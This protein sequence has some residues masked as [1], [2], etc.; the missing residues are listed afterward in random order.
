MRSATEAAEGVVA[1]SR[2]PSAR[3]RPL[4]ECGTS[5]AGTEPST[6]SATIALCRALAADA[7]RAVEAASEKVP[8]VTLRAHRVTWSG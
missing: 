6:A 8:L 2:P 3:D 5:S 7:L 4:Q 1:T